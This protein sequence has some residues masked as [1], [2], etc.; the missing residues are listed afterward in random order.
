MFETSLFTI[1]YGSDSIEL[2]L[3]ATDA[4]CYHTFTATVNVYDINGDLYGSSCE[5]SLFEQNGANLYGDNTDASVT[6]TKTFNL[7]FATSGTFI[8]EAT[9][10]TFSDTKTINIQVQEFDTVINTYVLFI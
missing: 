2:L 8:I 9:C 1:I 10:E 7:Y 4:F 6:G 5:V 3:S